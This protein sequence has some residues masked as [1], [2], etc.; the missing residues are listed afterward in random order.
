MSIPLLDETDMEILM[1]RNAHFGGNFDIMIRYYE[2]EGIGVN[3]E[4]ELSRMRMLAQSESS[5]GE[6]LAEKVLPTHCVERIEQAKDAYIKLRDIYDLNPVPEIPKLVSDL[7]L[8]EEDEPKK[9]I[10]AIVAKKEE[11]VEPLLQLIGSNDFYD[12]LFPGY[13]RAPIFAAKALEKIGDPR[14]IGPLF[15]ALSIDSL[16]ME[17]AFMHA[18]RTFGEEG[19]AF[20]LKQLEKEPYSTDNERAAAALASF[21]PDESIES[22]AVNLLGM[23]DVAKNESFASYL[24]CLLAE[25]TNASL[26]AKIEELSKKNDLPQN[27]QAECLNLIKSL[28]Q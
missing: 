6:D 7:I 4:F 26:I 9:E 11:G 14:A 20:L 3:E 18:L 12:P 19:K 13:G 28:K 5:I 2:D 15:S 1:H 8:S 22:V 21:L 27:V 24:T 23:N 10:A 16:E 25:T 17:L